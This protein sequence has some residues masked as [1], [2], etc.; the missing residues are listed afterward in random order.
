M[1]GKLGKKLRNVC[2]HLLERKENTSKNKK[3]GII[4]VTEIEFLGFRSALGCGAISMAD[5]VAETEV[6]FRM[7]HS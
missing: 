4:R 1:R 6:R 7:R 2:L 5:I 3:K